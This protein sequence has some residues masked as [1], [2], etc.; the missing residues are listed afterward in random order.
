MIVTFTCDFSDLTFTGLSV[1]LGLAQSWK[2]LEPRLMFMHLV[3][4]VSFQVYRILLIMY[5]VDF[6][7]YCTWS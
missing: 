1:M 5:A 2:K 6:M 4:T 3:A 7:T